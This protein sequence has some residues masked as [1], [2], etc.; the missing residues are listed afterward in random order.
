QKMTHTGTCPCN[1]TRR[2]MRHSYERN[3][4]LYCFDTTKAAPTFEESVKRMYPEDRPR[5][6][7]IAERAN[8]EGKHFEA[9]FRLLLP[10][11]TTRYVHGLG[12]PVFNA[13]G[14]L[15]EHL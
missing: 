14:D 9:H 4:R 11:G 1:M 7:E 13:S 10:D 8:S 2:E 5:V 15:V 6:V 3:S 12:H